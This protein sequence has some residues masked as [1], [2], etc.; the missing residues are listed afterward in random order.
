MSK[1]SDW[2][3]AADLIERVE[4]AI[5]RIT[6]GAGAMRI[7]AD[8]TDPDLV[9]VDC[10]QEI[11]TLRERERHFKEREAGCC[12]EDVGFE[13]YIKAL[14]E[15]AEKA[16]RAQDAAERWIACLRDELVLAGFPGGDR[17]VALRSFR[18]LVRQRNDAHAAAG[19]LYGDLVAAFALG[20]ERFATA[21][22][23]MAFEENFS[24]EVLRR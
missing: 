8:M 6:S 24:P 2:R 21:D 5:K 13:E 23:I 22:M 15:R 4:A 16:E 19:R 1:P 9:L 11:L 18:A 10:K 17:D 14:R 7:P 12:P 20:G 3:L